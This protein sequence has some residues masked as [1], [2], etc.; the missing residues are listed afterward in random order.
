MVVSSDASDNS[1]L[2]E[3]SLDK[4][5]NP[6][7][8]EIGID[9]I[10]PDE[11]AIKI[12]HPEF[13]SGGVYPIELICLCQIAATFKPQALFEIG[14]FNGRTTLNLAANTPGSAKLLTL[15]LP[16]G[17][18]GATALRVHDRDSKYMALRKVGSYFQASAYRAKITQL[19][20]DS[21]TFDYS[22]YAGKMDLVLVDGAHS[23]DYVL[24]DSLKTLPLLT[25]GCGIMLWH[26]Y[27][28]WDEVTQALDKLFEANPAFAG[29][30]HIRGTSLVIRRG[31]VPGD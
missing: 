7:I 1:P 29:M 12:H 21:A 8:P 18:A 13:Q 19:Y 4:N 24:S 2:R 22:P 23:F 6:R 3:V 15:D 9:E 26:D 5:L 27:G 11:V 10:C 28:T 17:A 25:P 16:E 20:G 14:T 31:P 30:R